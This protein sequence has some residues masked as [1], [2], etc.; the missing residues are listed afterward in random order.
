MSVLLLPLILVATLAV[1]LSG[2]WVAIALIDAVRPGN[3][4]ASSQPVDVPGRNAE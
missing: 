2:V 4:P 1:I 3:R